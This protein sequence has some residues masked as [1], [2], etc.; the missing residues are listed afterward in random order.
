MDP[1]TADPSES[2]PDGDNDSSVIS[3][4][5]GSAK[6][7]FSSGEDATVCTQKE[8]LGQRETRVVFRL[9]LLVFLVMTLAAAAVSITVYFITSRS[10]Q[11]LFETQFDGAASKVL[12]TFQ[13]VLGQN[14]AAIT[15]LSVA[16]IAHGIDHSRDWPFVTL[17]SFQQRSSTVRKLSDTLLLSVCPLVTDQDRREYEQLIK[18]PDIYWM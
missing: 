15:T 3:S 16:V 5:S 11:D 6:G 14:V 17:S 8:N 4:Q 10:E 2:A 18:T 9:R 1:K 13:N 12:E 7:S